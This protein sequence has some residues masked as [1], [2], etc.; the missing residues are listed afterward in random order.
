MREGSVYERE[1]RDRAEAIIG[2]GR[3][4]EKNK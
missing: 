1:K 3:Q 4:Q 2:G